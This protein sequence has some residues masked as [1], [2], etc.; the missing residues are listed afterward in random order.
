M[1]KQAASVIEAAGHCT[2]C[3]RNVWQAEN[4]GRMVAA[5]KAVI[6]VGDSPEFAAKLL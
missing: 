1:L 4:P 3:A 6:H 5:L 2:T